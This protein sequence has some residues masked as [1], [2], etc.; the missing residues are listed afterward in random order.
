MVI[1]ERAGGYFKGISAVQPF[2]NSLSQ[3]PKFLR[4]AP[5]L[6]TITIPIHPQLA[7]LSLSISIRASPY[8]FTLPKSHLA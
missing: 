2:H 1:G 5:M 7:S 6:I 8:P 3:A 4:R